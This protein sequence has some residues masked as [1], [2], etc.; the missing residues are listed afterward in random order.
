MSQVLYHG[1][2]NGMMGTGRAHEGMC[3]ADSKANATRYGATVYMCEFAGLAIEECAGYDREENYA[4]ADSRKFRA[5]A[6]ARGVDILRYE[7]E[8]EAGQQ[9]T[10]YR[11]VS[12]RAVDAANDQLAAWDAVMII[13]S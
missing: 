4:P 2:H 8:D 5:A 12:D 1:T 3:F 7:D 11:L 6:A 10:C 9:H 13:K